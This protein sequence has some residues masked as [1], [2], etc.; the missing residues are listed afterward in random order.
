MIYY[1]EP[2]DDD[3]KLEI[4]SELKAGNLSR[5]DQLIL[6]HIRLAFAIAK[7]YIKKHNLSRLYDEL[8][9]AAAEGVIIAVDRISKGYLKHNNATGYI[10]KF[11]HNS[12]IQTWAKQPIVPSPRNRNNTETHSF[13]DIHANFDDSKV[14]SIHETLDCIIRTQ[15]ERRIVDLR[16]KG[17]T[18][19]QIGAIMGMPHQ[20]IQRLRKIL[21]K[22]FERLTQHD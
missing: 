21:R 17:Y 5:K 1:P 13:L 4:V 16:I 18:D 3:L 11:V 6:S 22:R 15:R 2:L 7:R 12:I 20:T 9:S 19:V 14:I 8:N 10:V